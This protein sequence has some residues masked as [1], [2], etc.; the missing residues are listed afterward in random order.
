MGYYPGYCLAVMLYLAVLTIFASGIFIFSF[1]LLL[2][3]NLRKKDSAFLSALMSV[4]IVVVLSFGGTK[5]FFD[6]LLAI[7]L[8]IDNEAGVAILGQPLIFPS[9]QWLG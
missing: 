3:T 5:L 4:L 1:L 7:F 9:R 2:A 6:F 8:S